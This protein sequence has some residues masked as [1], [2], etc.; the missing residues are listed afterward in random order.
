MDFKKKVTSSRKVEKLKYEIGDILQSE[1][2]SACYKVV[3]FYV[4]D[5]SVPLLVKIDGTLSI[6]RKTPYWNNHEGCW[7]LLGSKL[8]KIIN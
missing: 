8:T 3:G 2:T 4:N 6:L 5:T 1:D 7:K